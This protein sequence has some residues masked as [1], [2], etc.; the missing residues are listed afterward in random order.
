MCYDHRPVDV[1][2]KGIGKLRLY[3]GCKGYSTHTLLYGIYVAGNTSVQVAEDFVSQIDLNHVCC[4]ELKAKVNLCQTPVNIV[5]TKTT[6]HLEDL[7]SASTKVTDL[8]KRVDEQ[9][10]KNHHVTYGNTHSVVLV[11]IVCVVSI[12]LLFKLYTFTF[13]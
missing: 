13:R 9:Q 10:W 4:E 6:A 2:L 12:Y 11:L 8:I 7:R 1:N 3:P 5:Y